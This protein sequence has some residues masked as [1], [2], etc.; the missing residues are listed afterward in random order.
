MRGPESG[1]KWRDR[2]RTDRQLAAANSALTGIDPMLPH[3][4]RCAKRMA[5]R[6]VAFHVEHFRNGCLELA[7]ANSLLFQRL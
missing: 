3:G 1:E 4:A 5:E 7:A 2:R 6:V